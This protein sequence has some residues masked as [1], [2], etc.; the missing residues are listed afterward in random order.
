[1]ICHRDADREPGSDYFDRRQPERTRNLL[2]KRLENL[3]FKFSL[4][5]APKTQG[6]SPSY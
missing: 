1:M 6:D 2:V 5:S 4:E 3:G